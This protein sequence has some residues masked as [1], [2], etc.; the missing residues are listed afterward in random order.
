MAA[1]EEE[2][3]LKDVFEQGFLLHCQIEDS[4]EPSNSEGFQEKVTTAVDQFV[5]AT[6]MVNSLGLFSANE[7]LAEVPTSELR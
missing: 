7:E 2:Y 5:R 1:A 6:E 4:D 3:S